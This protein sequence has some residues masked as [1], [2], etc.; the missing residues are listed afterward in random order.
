MSPTS[1]RGRFLWHELMSEDTKTA[2]KFYT[3]IIGWKTEPFPEDASYTMFVAPT[4]AMA[5]LMT[6]PAEAKA[7][8]ARSCWMCYI[9]SD[10][11][12][13]TARQAERLGGKVLRAPADIPSVGRFAVLQDPQ[14]AVFNIFMPFSQERRDWKPTLGDFSWHELATTNHAAAF[15]FYRQLFGWEKTE[16]MDMGPMGVYQMYGLEGTTMGGMFNKPKEMPF[17][18]NWL[19]Y[20]LVKDSKQVASATKQAGGKVINGPM[21]VP[22]GDWIADCFDPQGVRFAVHSRKPAAKAAPRK[23]AKAKPTAAAKPAA[24]T[25][26]ARKA[27]ASAKPSARKRAAA[28]RPASRPTAR[29]S[30]ASRGGARKKTA[31]R[32]PVRKSAARKRARAKR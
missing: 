21:E 32:S 1:I 3:R 7:M 12:D 22:G 17:P 18:S 24:K 8:G 29:K 30:A 9:G 27:S 5:G 13:A 10:D 4:G 11:V 23:A 25:K 16:A 15:E 6:L 28:K 14:G 2:A 26:P 19:P 31:T 20:I